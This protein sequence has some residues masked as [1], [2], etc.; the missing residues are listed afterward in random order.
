V[1]AYRRGGKLVV[2]TDVNVSVIIERELEEEKAP[3]FPH[4]VK[5]ANQKGLSEIQGEI[6]AAQAATPDLSRSL[7]W[8]NLYRYLP[9]FVRSLLWRVLLCSPACRRRLTG[10][11]GLSAVGMFGTGTGWGIPLPTYTL[12]VTVGGIA[13][14]PGVYDG[15]IAIREYLCL[16][17]SFDHNVVDGAPAARFARRFRELIERGHGLK[18]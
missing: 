10:T 15:Q 11:V 6:R 2:A 1:Q 3:L 14:K 16:T 5:A 18:E 8:L 17:I 7:R 4:V 9:G 12:N 13:E